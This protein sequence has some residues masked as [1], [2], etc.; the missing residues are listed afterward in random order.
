MKRINELIDLEIFYPYLLNSFI[1]LSEFLRK[2]RKTRT[3]F[4][5]KCYFSDLIYLSQGKDRLILIK[6]KG[7]GIDVLIR[8][9]CNCILD[10]SNTPTLELQAN[11]S[12]DITI[13]KIRIQITWIVLFRLAFLITIDKLLLILQLYLIY[14]RCYTITSYVNS[15]YCLPYKIQFHWINILIRRIKYS[16]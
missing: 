4:F 9:L 12:T 16:M 10:S 11:V 7:T 1:F 3:L 8:L 6:F 14:W 13:C 5:R 2:I 15:P